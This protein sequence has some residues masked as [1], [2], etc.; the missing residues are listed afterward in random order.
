M[1]KVRSAEAANSIAVRWIT[2]Y[3]NAEV[4]PLNLVQWVYPPKKIHHP[5]VDTVWNIQLSQL[6]LASSDS[7]P[8]SSNF[9][10]SYILIIYYFYFYST[11]YLY[12]GILFIYIT[13]EQMFKIF[14]TLKP[15]AL[16]WTDY[17]LDLSD[18]SPSVLQAN[19]RPT[20]TV[21][22]QR[23]R[24][25]IC[26]VPKISLPCKHSDFRVQANLRL[27]RTSASPLDELNFIC[28]MIGNVVVV[29]VVVIL[30]KRNLHT[31]I[32]KSLY[33]TCVL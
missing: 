4:S 3:T 22:T 17:Q 26:P 11:V 19:S 16:V 31:K 30:A 33:T 18:W 24:S 15:T 21:P 25:Y 14:D 2:L 12:Y 7:L 5:I 20:S 32:S 9:K 10:R 13:D 8:P 28:R 6:S 23:K 1:S 27:T 29:I